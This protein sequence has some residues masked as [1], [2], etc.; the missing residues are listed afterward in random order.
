MIKL[1]TARTNVDHYRGCDNVS[2]NWFRLNRELPVAPFEEVIQYYRGLADSARLYLE[3]YIQGLFTEAEVEELR[4]YLVRLNGSSLEVHEEQFPIATNTMSYGSVSGRNLADFYMLDKE[5]GY[6]LSFSVWGYYDLRECLNSVQ[7]SES[8]LASGSKFIELLLA[9]L[10]IAE[11]D[12]TLQIVLK[13]TP[14]EPPA[15][16]HQVQEALARDIYEVDGLYVVQGLNRAGKLA[17]REARRAAKKQE[18]EFVP[19]D[20]DTIPF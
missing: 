3:G 5:P 10:D 6:N 9:R 2:F 19:E 13:D 16:W 4:E 14:A 18:P 12:G 20:E 8:H 17:E 15:V 11:R 7:I 1:Y